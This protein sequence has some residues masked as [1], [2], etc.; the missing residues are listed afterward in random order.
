MARGQTSR[1]KA[2]EAASK[3]VRLSIYYGTGQVINVLRIRVTRLLT[4]KKGMWK[5]GRLQNSEG[6]N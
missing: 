1:N 4:I 5:K 3:V 2:K 6:L